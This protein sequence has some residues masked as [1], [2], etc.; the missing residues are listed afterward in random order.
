MALTDEN[1]GM[2]TTMLV[3][4]TGNAYPYPVYPQNNGGGFGNGFNGDGGWWLIL[5]II[6][7]AGGW[8]NNNNGG[9][10][11]GQPVI[12][13]DGNSNG[14][15]RGFDQ[16]SI[17]GGIN[18]LQATGNN[19]STQICNSTAAIQNSLCNGFN[20]VNMAVNGA[21]NAITSQLYN[22]E[23]ANLNRSFAEQTANVQ[24]F[25]ALNSQLANC[26]CEN[27]AGIADVKYT[28]ATENCADRAALSDGIRDVI[29]NQT[30]STQRILDQL[31][32][33]K[34]DAKNERIADLERQL[35]MANLAASQTAQTA[36]IRAGQIAEID[37]MYNRL[38]DCPIPAMPV[39]GSQAIFTCPTNNSGCG[40][41]CNGNF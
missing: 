40:C 20:G 5:L 12:I 6:L 38:R 11:G 21:Q 35:T 36:Q 30:A 8:N 23:I 10:F 13:N 7:F 2:N 18:A 34:I 26:C 3:S 32:S 17:M 41:G 16:A 19:I 31:C 1:G 33:D 9:A 22:N 39:Y 24:G 37:A 27:R 28:I 14:V 15:Q 29:A 4:P 25:N